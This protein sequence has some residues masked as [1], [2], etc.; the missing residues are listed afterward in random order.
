M[1]VV[2]MQMLSNSRKKLKKADWI[3]LSRTTSFLIFLLNDLSITT[4]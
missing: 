4:Q 1:S 2:V 3:D